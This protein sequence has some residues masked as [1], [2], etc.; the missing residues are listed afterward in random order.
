MDTQE[1]RSVQF[2]DRL[3]G[4]MLARA[5]MK[6]MR[7]HPEATTT[8]S[9]TPEVR[10]IGLDPLRVLL[11]GSG[12][13]VGYG[14]ATHAEALTGALAEATQAGTRRG[15]IVQNRA[16]DGARI[17]Q[18]V[19]DLGEVGAAT[20]NTVVWCPSLLDVM[21]MPDRGQC[22]RSLTAGI[23]LLRDTARPDAEITLVG[24]PIPAKNGPIE[25]LARAVVPRFNR[26][27]IRAVAPLPNVRY[28]ESPS[29]TSLFDPTALSADY[30]R[31]LAEQ[32]IHPAAASEARS[33]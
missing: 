16:V 32:I 24:L 9:G 13:A 17:E 23:G 14:V 30:Y 27:L 25:E 12:L 22:H 18:T 29:F 20:F 3:R 4:F 1:I 10:L 11:I 15:V 19:D 28:A 7:E 21:R 2:S 31:R 26:A 6:G 8:A 5:V 33:A